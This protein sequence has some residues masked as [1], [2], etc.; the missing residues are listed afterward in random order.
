[1]KDERKDN[2][3]VDKPLSEQHFYKKTVIIQ[4]L[5]CDKVRSQSQIIWDK[6]NHNSGN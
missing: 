5:L 4:F 3:A 2:Y 6:M 1:M